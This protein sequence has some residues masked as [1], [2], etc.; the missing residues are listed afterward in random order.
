MNYPIYNRVI[1]FVAA[2]AFAG[3]SASTPTNPQAEG[4]NTA[5]TADG[6]AR[7]PWMS[8]EAAKASNLLYVSSYTNNRVTIY[9][10]IDGNAIKLVGSLSIGQ[11]GGMCTDKAGDVWVP[12]YESQTIEE[13]PH[14]GITPIRSIKRNTGY[15]YAC[16]VDPSTGNLAVTYEFPNGKFGPYGRVVVYAKGARPR[17]LGPNDLS[18]IGFVAYDNSGNLFVDGTPCYS[19][20]CDPLANGT[21]LLEVPSGGTGYQPLT[22]AGA[23][24]DQAT[25]LNWI[26][27]TLLLTNNDPSTH[28]VTAYKLLVRGSNATVV[29]TLRLKH[30]GPSYGVWVRA[31]LVIVPDQNGNIIRSYDLS[32]GSF[33]SSFTKGLSSPFATVV[34]QKT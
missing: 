11:P 8:P 34:S 31:G 19:S 4:T 18:P 3:C 32:N 21:L 12:S 6:G 25:A 2:C 22:I 14:G 28:K 27:P 9:T 24:I 30:A 23:T 13:F 7:N 20:Y 1:T 26:K 16:A 10:Y 33:V 29:G 17:T 5:V 15:P